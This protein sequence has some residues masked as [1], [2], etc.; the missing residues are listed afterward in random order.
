MVHIYQI[1][2]FR[3]C[4]VSTLHSLTVLVIPRA[5]PG[6]RPRPRSLVNVI[7]IVIRIIAIHGFVRVVVGIVADHHVL[8]PGQRRTDSDFVL[9]VIGSAAPLRLRALTGA[10]AGMLAVLAPSHE[11]LEWRRESTGAVRT[12]RRPGRLLLLTRGV[13]RS[14]VGITD[15]GDRSRLHLFLRCAPAPRWLVLRALA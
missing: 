12:G 8:S 11:P 14:H 9:G 15:D 13:L 7:I 5:V 2:D 3:C 4:F 6:S 10:L 1:D